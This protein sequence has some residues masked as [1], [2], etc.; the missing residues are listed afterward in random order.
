MAKQGCQLVYADAAN[1][2]GECPASTATTIH[3]LIYN[4][5]TVQFPHTTSTVSM[6]ITASLEQVL[7]WALDE[8]LQRQQNMPLY[9]L[10][11]ESQD[12]IRGVFMIKQVSHHHNV[13][14][15][16]GLILPSWFCP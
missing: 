12:L 13:H 11:Q 16:C 1:G 3:C 6:G 2:S 15:T 9:A 5:S 14:T 8:V 7:P 10:I 4:N